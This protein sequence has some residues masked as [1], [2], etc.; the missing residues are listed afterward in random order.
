MADNYLTK[1]QRFEIMRGQ[2]HTERATF[3]PSWRETSDY[4]LPRR[5]RFTVTDSNKGDRRNQKIIDST[6]TQ[7]IRTAR[8]G[9]QSGITNKARPW[10]RITTPD[11]KLAEVGSVK[12]FLHNLTNSMSSVLLR[13]N[14]YRSTG[15]MF[16]DIIGFATS[17]FYVERHVE[18][19]IHTQTF[20]I[21]S[22]A[23]GND[24]YGRA[25]VFIRDFRMTVRQLIEKFGNRNEKG[26][27]DWSRFST[28]V[29]RMWEEGRQLEQWIDVCHVICPNYDYDPKKGHSKFKKFASC[30][31]ERGSG[32]NGY[33][34]M[35]DEQETY[36]SEMGY[37][38]FPV[39]CPKWETSDGDVYGTSCPGIDI[40]GDVKAL[41][42]MQRRKAEAIEKMVRPPMTGPSALKNQAASI[43]PGNITYVDE[44]SGQNGFKP[45]YQVDPRINE[46]LLDIQ[47]HQKRIKSGC[48]EDLFKMIS[49]DERGDRTAF[50]VAKIHEEKLALLGPVMESIDEDF[51]DPFFD[52]L[53]N[54]MLALNMVEEA[55]EELQGQALK[56]DYISIM[57]QAQK[58]VGVG[59]MERFVTSMINNSALLKDPSIM[60]KVDMDEYADVYGDALGVNPRIIRSDEK[61]AEMRA[62]K[63]QQAAAMQK[64]E[65]AA[66]AAG[67]AKDLASA[68]MSGDNALTRMAQGG[69]QVMQ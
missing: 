22:Y 24:Q 16:A 2:L 41:Q 64:A 13:S 43:L 69:Q 18:R 3:M 51:L 14:F 60:D 44:S 28:H 49:I 8:A 27:I 57:H 35:R 62:Q 40:I 17:A 6:G 55:P 33:D 53:F 26:D 21:G 10:F 66:Q 46:L 45:A 38:Y 61:V 67:A 65:M 32:A 20:P 58:L 23:I 19:V 5:A 56:I 29:K 39:L 25:N 50:E 4:L 1:R 54:E 9:M 52:I 15:G 68:D 34:H 36:L 59:G 42:L 47:D 37:D 11:P 48:F 63:A 7:A 31:Y 12:D 30:Y